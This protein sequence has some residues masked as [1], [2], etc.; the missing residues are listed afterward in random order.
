MS[1]F[2]ADDVRILEKTLKIREKI[3]DNFVTEDNI[4]SSTKDIY[5]V[6]ALT[7]SIDANVLGKAKIKL[8]ESANKVNEETKNVLSGLL[9][10]LHKGNTPKEFIDLPNEERTTFKPTGMTLSEGELMR[11]IDHIDLEDV[12]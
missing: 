4:P 10:E 7:D 3:L 9:L 12:T 1:T 2:S 11:R 5:A 6:V 8:E